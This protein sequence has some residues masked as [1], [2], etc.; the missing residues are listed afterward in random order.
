M[1][2]IILLVLL[3]LFLAGGTM[4]YGRWGYGGM[5][6]AALIAIILVLLL[7]TGNLHF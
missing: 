3:V 6:P 2:A 5:S 1:L 7:L 4:N